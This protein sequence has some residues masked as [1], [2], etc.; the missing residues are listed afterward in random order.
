MIT[1]ADCRAHV[2]YIKKLRLLH[3]FGDSINSHT[4]RA[5]ADWARRLHYYRQ[6][7]NAMGHF[8]R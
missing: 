3:I 2:C 5:T 1:R 7:S 6:H 8:M 4:T